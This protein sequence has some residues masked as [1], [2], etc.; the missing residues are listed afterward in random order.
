MEK[1]KILIVD[2][3]H[4]N[5]QALERTL[6]KD[7]EVVAFTDPRKAI[8]EIGKQ[9][10]AVVVS[11]QRMPHMSGT[12][13]L[14]VVAKLSPL[15]TRIILTAYPD[16]HDIMQAINR[17][18]IYRYLTKPWDPI[19]LTVGVR[20]AV[21]HYRLVCEK[22][23]L[24]KDLEGKNKSLEQ[25]EKELI[26]LNKNLEMLVDKRTVELK[27]ANEKLS[28]LAQ[29]DPLT[30]LLNRR[31]FGLKFTEEIERAKRYDRPLTV[32][33]IDVDHFKLFNDMEGHVYGDEAL[34]KIAQTLSS[35]LRKSDILGRY[36]GEEF[37]LM[38]PE[39]KLH[40]ASEIC[41]RLRVSVEN[42]VFQGQ[43]EN[44]YLTVSIGL[45]TFPIHGETTEALVKIADQALYQ[46][47][48]GGRN[49]VVR[50]G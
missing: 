49:R 9:T 36:G 5:L 24:I 18:E 46:A 14:A 8:E 23:L 40:S 16:T 37:I 25:K 33:M 31:G 50:A 27:I 30:R 11:D 48:D 22:D 19:E 6:R 39:T 10:F 35:N 38:M 20:Q 42:C 43:K 41:E 1:Y 12:E 15:T 34:K 13:M 26:E 2:D 29:T 21:E 32:A 3:E 7:F 47:K 45:A 4:H 44:A 28:E 17:A